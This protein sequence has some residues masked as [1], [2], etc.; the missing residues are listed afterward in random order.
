M[1]VL[2]ARLEGG[3]WVHDGSPVRIRTED[4]RKRAGDY[5][6]NLLEYV[7]FSVERRYRSTEDVSRIWIAGDPRGPDT[8]RANVLASVGTCQ[9]RHLKDAL[10]AR[11]RPSRRRGVRCRWGRRPRPGP[12]LPDPS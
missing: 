6:A 9:R 8:S 1:R 4:E 2:G 3:R 12:G 10:T 11:P 7:G 5:V